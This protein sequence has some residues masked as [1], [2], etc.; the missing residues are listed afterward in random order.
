MY[1]LS[2]YLYYAITEEPGKSVQEI[3]KGLLGSLISV[4]VMKSVI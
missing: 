1:L 4:K 2:C 3:A